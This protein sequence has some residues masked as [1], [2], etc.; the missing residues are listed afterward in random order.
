M[1]ELLCGLVANLKQNDRQAGGRRMGRL[2]SSS[3]VQRHY[4]PVIVHPSL[5]KRTFFGHT[6][7][8]VSLKYAQPIFERVPTHRT[9]RD[10]SKKQRQ[11]HDVNYK[12]DYLAKDVTCASRPCTSF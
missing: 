8:I 9:V 4:I 5:L 11:S 12:A 6:L 3:L 2:I 1:L 10:R 7:K